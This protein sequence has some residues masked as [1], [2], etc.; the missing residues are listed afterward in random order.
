MPFKIGSIEIRIDLPSEQASDFFQRIYRVESLYHFINEQPVYPEWR[1][2]IRKMEFL[3][4][5]QGTVAL[6]G[7]EIKIEDVERVGK[8]ERETL[9]TDSDKEAANALEAYD[10]IDD[11]TIR[12]PDERITEPVI[13]QLHTIITRD[14]NYYLNQP[15]QYRNQPVKFGYPS[16]ESAL[17][18]IFAVQDAMAKLVDFVNTKTDDVSLSYFPLCRAVLAHYLMTLI[19]PFIDG[20]GRVARA[21]EALILHHYGKY[22]A[23]LFPINAKFYYR[24]RKKYFELLRHTDSTGDPLPFLFFA[25][26]GLHESLTEIKRGVLDK[27]TCTLIMDY[28]HQLR[29]QK[30]LLKRQTTLLE[31]AFGLNPMELSEFI[32]NPAIRGVYHN[33][34]E[35]TRKRDMATLL[36]FGLLKSEKVKT[37]DGKGKTTISANW[38]AL[39]YLTL[40]LDAIPHRY[41][42]AF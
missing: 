16:Q 9:T 8:E 42:E 25:I 22:E 32:N 13:K 21:V 17:K 35:S 6:E 15:G 39:K 24:Q 30:K 31:I 41:G 4:A 3:R 27:I 36:A 18:D 33:L 38:D 14:I 34:S 40:R 2:A 7:A 23:Y 19:H 37:P 28:A 12:N 11:W 10:F 29:R 20:N 1:E 5:V 26:D